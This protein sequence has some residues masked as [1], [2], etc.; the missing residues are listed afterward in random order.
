MESDLPRPLAGIFTVGKPPDLH[1][2]ATGERWREL[3]GKIG[4][5]GFVS[6]AL[7]VVS[8]REVVRRP[9]SPTY[10]ERLAEDRRTSRLSESP[11]RV[12]VP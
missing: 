6:R 5:R 2:C 1:L 3:I 12:A 11:P 7:G 9:E 10:E 4:V 8:D